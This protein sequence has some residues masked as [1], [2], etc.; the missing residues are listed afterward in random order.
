MTYAATLRLPMMSFKLR[1]S[2]AEIPARSPAE[3]DPDH[4]IGLA[5]QRGEE[6]AI[7]QLYERHA[8][9]IF[10]F[11]VSKLG[12]RAAAEDV[13]QQVFAELWRRSTE[14]DPKRAK[15]FT[16]V[17]LIARSRATDHLRRSVPVPH[18]PSAAAALLDERA[19]AE[20]TEELIER[21]RVAELLR[22]VPAEEAGI[23]RMRFYE[24]LS[25][26]EIAERT[27]T[28]LGTVKMR[29]VQALERMRALIEAEGA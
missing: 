21:W 18:E 27:G 14:Y 3:D 23:L 4:A 16:W 10:S 28:A 17:M 11:L 7:E 5:L 12:D 9:T 1:S 15:L 25:Q 6:G 26:R 8:R 20:P 24:G 29:M 22:R 13:H 2:A 19:G